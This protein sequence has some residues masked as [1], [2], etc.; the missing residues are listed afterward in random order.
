[1]SIRTLV[2]QEVNQELGK[3]NNMES[4][5]HEVH[6]DVNFD[7]NSLTLVVGQTG[8]GKTFNVNNDLTALKYV[9]NSFLK[10]FYVTNNPNDLTLKRMKSL[11]DIPLEIITYSESEEKIT[12]LR[13]WIQAYDKVIDEGLEDKISPQCREDFVNWCQNKTIRAKTTQLT[14]QFSNRF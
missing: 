12:D 2:R 9:P 8:S 3:F 7:Y 1:M 6:P 10:I 13:E 4:C 11:I 14:Y 5:Q